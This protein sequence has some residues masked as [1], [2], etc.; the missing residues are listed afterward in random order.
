[1]TS[2]QA[3]GAIRVTGTGR[4]EA[5]PDVAQIRLGASVL[6]ASAAEAI[7]TA[8]RVVGAIRTALAGLGVAG[9][10]AATAN[11]SVQAEQVW[12]EQHGPRV[13]GIRCQ[14]DL[15]V[16]VRALDDLG[17]VMGAA[18]AAGG[19]DVLLHGVEFGLDDVVGPRSRARELAWVDARNRAEQLAELAGR[20][21]GAVLDVVEGE[22]AGTAFDLASGVAK[23]TAA[24]VAVVPGQVGVEVV[25]AVRW[26]TG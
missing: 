5:P 13:T 18:L 19:D 15:R 23:R 11:L 26:A 17:R 6:R 8:E 16:T 10:E 22:P 3:P 9:Q 1:V 25:L 12:T 21:L 24:E 20:E 7:A 2:A 14:H 4:V